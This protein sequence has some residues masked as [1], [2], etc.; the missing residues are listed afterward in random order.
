MPASREARATEGAA[1]MTGR[2]ACWRKV[3]AEKSGWSLSP[4]L[5]AGRSFDRLGTRELPG[6]GRGFCICRVRREGFFRWRAL[7]IDNLVPQWRVGFGPGRRGV[8]WA[9]DYLG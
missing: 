1:A 5:G 9:M 7:D 3:R 4:S 8:R 2:A 6:S